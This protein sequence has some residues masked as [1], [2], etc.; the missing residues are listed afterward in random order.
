MFSGEN[1]HYKIYCFNEQDNSYTNLSKVAYVVLLDQNEQSIFEHRVQLFDGVGYGDF[2]IP[3]SVPS[4]NYKIIA[5]TQWMLNTKNHFYLG[6]LSILNPYQV[7]EAIIAK[8]TNESLVN[9]VSN[10]DITNS[11]SANKIGLSVDKEVYSKRD[12]VILTLDNK[13]EEN[14]GS[15][16][17]SVVRKN[18]FSKAKDISAVDFVKNQQDKI[19]S[20]QNVN[21]GSSVFLP[22]M[23]GE[24]VYGKIDNKQ[25]ASNSLKKDLGLSFPEEKDEVYFVS[26]DDNGEFVVNLSNRSS[27]NKKLIVEVMG[28]DRNEFTVNLYDIPKADFDDL[29]FYDFKITPTLK[30]V[31]VERSVHNQIENN[32]YNVKPDTLVTKEQKAPF[33]GEQ[34]IY[35]YKLDDYTRFPTVKETLIEVVEGMWST[36]DENGKD[37]FGIRGYYPEQEEISYKPLL[38]IDGVIEQDQDKII[39]S[40]AKGIVSISYIRDRYYLGSKVFGGIVLLETKNKDYAETRVANHITSVDLPQIKVPNKKYFTQKYDTNKAYDRIPDYRNQLLWKQDVTFDSDQKIIQFFTSD[41][42]GEFE[43]RLEGF[44]SLGVPV[45]IKKSFHVK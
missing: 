25:N 23:R 22:E 1:L 8:G 9:G 10:S 28:E 44:N 24:L 14:K 26:T 45:S 36:R 32:Y 12:K 19:R 15:Y 3:V 4:G 38:L 39:N 35:T 41:L 40:E 2:F 20:K 17:V 7:N 37:I 30:D 43:I 42:E 34:D 27:E 11:N 6:D 29:N 16:S 5:Y 18:T 31:I 21:V 33:Y 13:F